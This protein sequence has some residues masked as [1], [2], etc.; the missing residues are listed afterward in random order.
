ME[1][2]STA[3]GLK[4][5][6]YPARG[7]PLEVGH[8][9]R[10]IRR[11]NNGMEVVVKNDPCGDSEIFMRA[12]IFERSDENIAARRSCEDRQPLDNG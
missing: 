2:P 12:A 11:G 5:F 6:N 7:M 8:D 9:A 4:L 10:H 3:F 1:K